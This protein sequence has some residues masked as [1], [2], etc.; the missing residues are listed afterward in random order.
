[1]CLHLILSK[2]QFVYF[3]SPVDRVRV[4]VGD[5]HDPAR[6]GVVFEATLRRLSGEGTVKWMVLV[7]KGRV[8]W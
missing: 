2:Q 4:Q 7:T 3:K 6:R 1:M 8:K 5:G